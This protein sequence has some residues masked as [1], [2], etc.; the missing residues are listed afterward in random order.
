[1][2]KEQMTQTRHSFHP[3]VK[4]SFSACSRRSSA[5]FRD[6]FIQKK[7]TAAGRTRVIVERDGISLQRVWTGMKRAPNQ[8]PEKETQ[9]TLETFK[10][11]RV[12]FVFGRYEFDRPT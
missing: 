1:L 4:C 2:A 11:F 5:A 9:K 7:K 12:S 10:P 8:R 6:A 3:L